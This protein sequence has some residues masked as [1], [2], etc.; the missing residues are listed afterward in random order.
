MSS[1]IKVVQ[2][3][4]SRMAIS[5][6]SRVMR[7]RMVTPY[8]TSAMM[9]RSITTTNNSS[10]T[11]PEMP[12]FTT[13]GSKNTKEPKS[14]WV[15]ITIF[16]GSFLIGWYLTQHMTFTDVMAYWKYDKLPQDS[17]QVQRYRFEIM[18]RLEKLPIMKQIRENN[19]ELGYYEVFPKDSVPGHKSVKEGNQLINKTL[20]TPGGIA[21][22]PKFFYNP[23]KKEVVGI[24]HL[25][26]KLT[27]YPFIVH[28]GILATVMEDLM[29]EG[30]QIIKQKNGEKTNEL[31]ISYKM[32]TF[33]N[34][35]VIVRTT[36]VDDIGK[37]SVNM[38]VD[39]MDQNGQNVLVKGS[40]SF[41]TI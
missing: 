24:Y 21:I 10:S 41:K 18:N 38:K 36:Q 14:K 4:Y 8:T 33:A 3:V 12:T 39:L 28:G 19:N 16:S 15:P 7:R 37:D 23:E 20:L 17:E 32:P 35:F 30:I 13:N 26:M 27:G 29:R 2:N 34:Q 5:R 1:K 31:T 40:G 11:S 22:P 25:G 9:R 6:M